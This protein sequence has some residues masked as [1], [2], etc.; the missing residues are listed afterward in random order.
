LQPSASQ[1]PAQGCRAF[2]FVLE[3]GPTDYG[4][5][6]FIA[7]MV[8]LAVIE[9]IF[10]HLGMSP[11]AVPQCAAALR[12][13]GSDNRVAQPPGNPALHVNWRGCWLAP[14]R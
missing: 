7:A 13:A 1:Q 4:E 11:V 2:A 5:P 9:C 8:E 10:A 14:R 6:R 12:L 3:Q